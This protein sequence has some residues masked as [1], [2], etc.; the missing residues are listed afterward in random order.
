MTI[1]KKTDG[2]TLRN[3]AFNIKEINIVFFGNLK[4]RCKSVTK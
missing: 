1:L 4:F 2:Q 3:S